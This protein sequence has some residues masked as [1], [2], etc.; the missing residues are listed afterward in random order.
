MRE[1][2]QILVTEN[3]SDPR[4]G[5]R[6]RALAGTSPIVS[7]NL[8]C[9]DA[10]I[11]AITWQWIFAREFQIPLTNGG[12]AALFLTAWLIYL[13]DRLADT[14]RLRAGQPLSLRQR[15]C[16]S[17]QIVWF[18]VIALLTAIDLW[19]IS[20]ELT[21]ATIRLGILLGA[22]AIGYLCLNYWLGELWKTLPVKE[23]CIGLLFAFG[24]AAAIIPQLTSL[25]G[26]A[27]AF[28]L[29][30]A[31]CSLNCISIAIWERGLD[32]AQRKNS[33]ATRWDRLRP[34]VGTSIVVLASF[35]IMAG[36]L[37]KQ[38]LCFF[39]AIS[40]LLLGALDWFGERL[41]PDSRTALADLV[42]LTPLLLCLR[43]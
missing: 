5:K 22:I 39:I 38:T 11:V 8:V 33:I 28:V 2:H 43:P 27:P 40:A 32:R 36:L 19:I 23:I 26:F 12:R 15:F 7:L 25:G 13:A 35:G 10:P 16:Q 18:I 21:G 41:A 30:A 4:A 14:W 9:L 42:L 24:T 20:S 31:L 29:F 17:H 3:F 34:F 6:T 1:S 37:S